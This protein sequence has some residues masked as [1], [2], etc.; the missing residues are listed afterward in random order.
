M[1]RTNQNIDVSSFRKRI[2]DRGISRVNHQIA[3]DNYVCFV[4]ETKRQD[5]LPTEITA[6][7]SLACHVNNEIKN[8]PSFEIHFL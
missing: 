8:I 7:K 4:A 6:R 1:P 3:A 5:S 2:L